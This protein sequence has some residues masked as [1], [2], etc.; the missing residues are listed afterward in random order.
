MNTSSSWAVAER[1]PVF[2]FSFDVVPYATSDFESILLSFPT[3]DL[4]AAWIN[5]YGL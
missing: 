4:N 5:D 3:S 2:E 1:L